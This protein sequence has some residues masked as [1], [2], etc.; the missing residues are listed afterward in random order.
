MCGL[1][2]H[3]Q[4]SD[5]GFRILNDWTYNTTDDI[6]FVH[7]VK[8]DV[9]ILALYAISVEKIPSHTNLSQDIT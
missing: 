4:G 5:Q 9:I 2:I 1:A 7:I 3:A 8:N 6:F